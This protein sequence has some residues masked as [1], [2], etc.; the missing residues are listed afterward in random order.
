[1]KCNFFTFFSI[2]L[3][4]FSTISCRTQSKINSK[5]EVHIVLL[6][7]QSNMSGVGHFKSLDEETISRINALSN[8][9]ML[10]DTQLKKLIPLSELKN[11]IW[12]KDRRS[13]NFGPELFLGLTLAEKH[14]KQ[15]YLFIKT[16][17]GGTALY[18]AWNP[19]WSLE[20]SQAIERGEYK[21]GLKLYK[22]HI[23][24]IKAQLARLVSE[25]KTYKI[26]G[27]VWMQGEN[28]GALDVSAKNYGKNLK[29]LL[30]SYRRDLNLPNL[31]FVA[32]QTNSHYGVKGGSDMVR[33]GFLDFEKSED[34]V[35]VIKTLR[36]SPYTDFPK[37][38]DNVHYNAEGQK[39]FGIAFAKALMTLN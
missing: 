1:M 21:Q 9:V 37:H 18:G 35:A 32:G 7:G 34:H 22:I 27:M 24:Q 2:A 25:G 6:G 23:N 19:N 12:G 33:Q 17:H 30:A 31:P 3:L 16:A 5:E 36:D 10:S 39:R 11:Q 15:K 29:E 38:S 20:Q 28:D 8:R 4:T 14:P 13:K 26:L